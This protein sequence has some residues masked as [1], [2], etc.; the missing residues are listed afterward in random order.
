[1]LDFALPASVR[2]PVEWMELARL[3][4]N[5]ELERGFAG[6]S[7]AFMVVPFLKRVGRGWCQP[8]SGLAG[9]FTGY[10]PD[11]GKVLIWWEK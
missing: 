6:F 5:C 7:G 2:G 3:A 11:F 4:R 10:E 8:G 1:M 9:E